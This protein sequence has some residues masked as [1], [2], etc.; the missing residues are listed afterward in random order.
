MTVCANKSAIIDEIEHQHQLMFMF[1]LSG[2]ATLTTSNDRETKQ[3]QVG[4]SITL[5]SLIDFKLE[6]V[7]DVTLF[8]IVELPE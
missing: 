2:S 1:V 4:T 6:V 5:P 8:L 3:L 7:V